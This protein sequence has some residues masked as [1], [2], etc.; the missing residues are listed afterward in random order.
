MAVAPG[1][2]VRAI[3]ERPEKSL[4]KYTTVA[5]DL[6]SFGKMLEI[7]GEVMGKRTAY[8]ECTPESWANAFG[9]AGVELAAQFQWGE[10]L[11]EWGKLVPDEEYVNKEELGIGDEVP[12]FTKAIEAL[13]EHFA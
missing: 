10:A 13:K 8:L 11:E 1:I 6:L 5:T 7:W 2:W 12:G 4:G 3:L 9:E